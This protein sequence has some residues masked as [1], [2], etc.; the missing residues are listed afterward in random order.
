MLELSI[1]RRFCGP[2]RSGNGGYTAGLVA[3]A[4]DASKTIEVTLHSPPPL[5]TTL[6]VV[7]A[8]GSTELRHG[9]IVVATGRKREPLSEILPKAVSIDAAKQ[10][11]HRFA[12]RHHH[13]IPGCFVCGT[14]NK[15]GLK[16]HAGEVPG[17]G[18]VAADWMPDVDC[19]DSEGGVRD[20][21]GWAALDCPGYF[22]AFIGEVP[23]F[24]LLGR[25]AAE[26]NRWP[27]LN[28]PCTVLGWLQN[29]QGRKVKVGSA[30][31]TG[32]G[33]VLARSEAVWILVDP[34]KYL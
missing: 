13:Q 16:L 27:R 8:D 1:G 31:Y 21:I 3:G 24:A 22:G 10:A 34:Q 14:E 17:Q 25:I 29:K 12:G 30:I 26:V 9:E 15:E 28:E 11:R 19:V 23:I 4:M 7:R 33:E 18:V 32:E 2:P 20:E 5:E 6:S